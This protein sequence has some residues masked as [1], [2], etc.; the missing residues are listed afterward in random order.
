MNIW[1]FNFS[2]YNKPTTTED[3]SHKSENKKS[4]DKVIPI[5]ATVPKIVSAPIPPALH[6]SL[7][8]NVEAAAVE[9]VSSASTTLKTVID[10]AVS[11]NKK[12]RTDCI[13]DIGVTAEAV[14]KL[15]SGDFS[16]KDEKIQ[17]WI[18]KYYH[19]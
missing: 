5:V 13:K 3:K 2:L 11:D 17:V 12:F 7:P 4:D 1:Y 16:S 15:K 9:A 18:W 19:I 8:V 6:L 10:D 14:D